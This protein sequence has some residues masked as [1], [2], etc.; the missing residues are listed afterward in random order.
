MPHFIGLLNFSPFSYVWLADWLHSF[1]SIGWR[2][3]KKLVT[4][5]TLEMR[6]TQGMSE[7]PMY[8]SPQSSP[9]DRLSL[10][11]NQD[12]YII[13]TLIWKIRKCLFCFGA[14]WWISGA[15]TTFLGM[16][17][18]HTCL[19]VTV[20]NSVFS[21]S[22]KYGETSEKYRET[23]EKYGKTSEKQRKS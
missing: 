21:A 13:L 12:K 4:W 11:V 15:V 20:S 6:G 18:K 1:H 5:V 17:R 16:A 14:V 3:H 7:M 10:G 9:V 19:S 22:E 8:S 23:S 2:L